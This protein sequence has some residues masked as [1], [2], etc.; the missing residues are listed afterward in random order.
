MNYITSLS[1][2]SVY[3][4]WFC[5]PAKQILPKLPGKYE[6]RPAVK[7]LYHLRPKAPASL[8]S[9]ASLFVNPK[10]DELC[11]AVNH[12]TP[13]GHFSGRTAPLISR[14]CIFYIYSTNIR[15]QYF[16]H[17]AHSP[18]FPLQNAVYFVMQP[19][20]VPILF[21]FY[22]QGVLKFKRRSRR[23]SVKKHFIGFIVLCKPLHFCNSVTHKCIDFMHFL[24]R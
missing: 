12:L 8:V 4:I 16:K 11:P 2:Y 19:F 18:F 23:Q 9:F 14:R 5:P 15:T 1:L 13:N 3:L 6:L 10:R 7:K 22:T 21:T 17:A 20:L 24:G